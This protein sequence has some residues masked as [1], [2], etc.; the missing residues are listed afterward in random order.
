MN[1]KSFFTILL[2]IGCSLTGFAAHNL[3]G[4]ITYKKVYPNNPANHEFAITVNTQHTASSSE[5]RP[6]LYILYGDEE[7]NAALDSIERIEF[8]ILS[9]IKYCT[10]KSF[11]TYPGQGEFF[12]QMED[13]NRSGGILNME[14]SISEPFFLESKLSITGDAVATNENSVVLLNSTVPSACID[15]TWTFNAAAFDVDGDS[16]VYELVPCKGAGGQEINS[17][18]LPDQIPGFTYNGDIYLYTDGTIFW[19]IPLIMGSYSFALKVTEY[20]S[21][22]VEVGYVIKDFTVVVETCSEPPAEFSESIQD[23]SVYP[24]TEIELELLLEDVIPNLAM[25]AS[26]GPLTD[27]YNTASFEVSTEVDQVIGTFNWTPNTGDVRDQP[28][29]VV[30]NSLADGVGGEGTEVVQITVLDPG[31]NSIR[32]I[33]SSRINVFPNPTSNSVTLEMEG[34]EGQEYNLY[35]SLGEM[36]ISGSVTQ[37]SQVIDISSLSANVYFLGIENNVI[38][39]VKT[40]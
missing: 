38:R 24:W 34:V 28:Y 12:I 10:Y 9:E 20:N 3:A 17:W 37:K 23:I 27:M 15:E 1:T 35:N 30:F 16:L 14:E 13:P 32:S 39:L 25:T 8:F 7:Q 19:E 40:D 31:E 29:L 4:E 36:L 33:E 22:G 11:H 6:Y 21:Q 2:L 18:S 26:G 5:D